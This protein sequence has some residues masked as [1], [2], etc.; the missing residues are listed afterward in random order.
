M[1][2]LKIS[3]QGSQGSVTFLFN[4]C[5]YLARWKD[6]GTTFSF[7]T[8]SQFSQE[9][10]NFKDQTIKIISHLYTPPLNIKHSA[11]HCPDCFSELPNHSRAS[12]F[13]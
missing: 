8:F 12:C 2:P 7:P 3:K 5:I 9:L 4:H 13:E 6:K 10:E 1:F 11:N